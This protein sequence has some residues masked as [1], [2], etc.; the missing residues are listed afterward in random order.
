M[1]ALLRM[2]I[3]EDRVVPVSMKR[4]WAKRE[5]VDSVA[6]DLDVRG[7]GCGVQARADPEARRGRG[8]GDELDDDFVRDEGLAP[9]VLTDEGK[10]AVL[11]LVPL[12]RAGRKVTHGD[13]QS[14]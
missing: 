12:A 8:G 5:C 4:C 7:I 14:E 2:A 9:P 6:A 1:L 11:N 13:R 3:G 10:E